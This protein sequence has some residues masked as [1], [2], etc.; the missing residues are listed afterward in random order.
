MPCPYRDLCVV[1]A[2]TSPYKGRGHRQAKPVGTRKTQGFPLA[3]SVFSADRS[4]RTDIRS[5]G[6]WPIAQGP[7]GTAL[8]KPG[9]TP[10]SG[11]ADDAW[12]GRC[13]V[14]YGVIVDQRTKPGGGT[15]LEVFCGGYRSCPAPHSPL[16]ASAPPIWARRK[17]SDAA[18]L[19]SASEGSIDIYAAICWT[20]MLLKDLGFYKR[21]ESR[22]MKA[23]NR[24]FNEIIDG[25]KQFV[26]PVFQRDFSWTL[27]QFQQLWRDVER[28]S[29]DT[30]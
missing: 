21:R 23:V 2:L 1:T 13:S 6:S 4:R 29:S 26:I 16:L 22:A 5:R 15:A 11:R 27:E 18:V 24:L 25:K 17:R 9:E 3:P 12:T 8:P 14:G 19:L 10:P 30:S 28:A 20:C 7:I